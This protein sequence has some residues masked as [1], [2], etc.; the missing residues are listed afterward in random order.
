MTTDKDQFAQP[1][2]FAGARAPEGL[3]CVVVPGASGLNLATVTSVRFRVRSGTTDDDRIWPATIV[4]Q[5]SDR[6]VARHEFD[7]AGVETRNPG[8]YRIIPE[9]IFH[10]EPAAPDDPPIP[11]GVR[12]AA[13]FYLGVSA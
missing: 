3:N 9:L 5:R 1:S 2:I 12:R 6:L 8:R 13:A 11:D 10:T 4:A 7:A